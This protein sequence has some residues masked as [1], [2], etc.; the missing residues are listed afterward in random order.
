MFLMHEWNREVLERG[1]S[2][3]GTGWA[4]WAPR[5][6]VGIG[7]LPTLLLAGPAEGLRLS[8]ANLPQ[9]FLMALWAF[10]WWQAWR[11]F[12][13]RRLREQR[14]RSGHLIHG[15]VVEA[16]LEGPVAHHHGRLLI[17]YHF[18]APTGPVDAQE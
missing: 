17:T 4:V 10:F 7:P 5:V 16:H 6:F 2:F 1:P 14:L 3:Y 13:P 12:E 18:E 15:E 11:N 9:F 8:V